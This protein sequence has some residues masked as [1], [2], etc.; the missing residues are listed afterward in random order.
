[1]L[2][3]Q[4]KWTRLCLTCACMGVA[5]VSHCRPVQPPFS[6]GLCGLFLLAKY[7]QGSDDGC[8]FVYRHFFS[9]L[10]IFIFYR[11]RLCA[12]LLLISSLQLLYLPICPLLLLASHRAVRLLCLLERVLPL[13]MSRG[14]TASFHYVPGSCASDAF[15]RGNAS[16]HHLLRKHSKTSCCKRGLDYRVVAD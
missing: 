5:A 10:Q 14:T 6:G 3:V 2:R 12:L 7:A 1:M 11:T 13:A 16:Y 4:S 15:Y 8:F 9:S